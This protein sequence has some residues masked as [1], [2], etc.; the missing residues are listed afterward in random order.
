MGNFSQQIKLR[1]HRQ[2]GAGFTLVELMTV[3]AIIGILTAIGL[4][5]IP[6]QR[7]R[8]RNAQRVVDVNIIQTA[9]ER[10]YAK[11]GTYP[12]VDC[13][14]WDDLH[15]TWTASNVDMTWA[16]LAQKLGPYTG[17]L[18]NDSLVLQT[19]PAGH[20]PY[21][22]L[23]V[24]S[25][26]ADQYQ[27]YVV[28]AGMEKGGWNSIKSLP[29]VIAPWIAVAHL[30]DDSGFEDMTAWNSAAQSFTKCNQTNYLT[31]PIHC[32]EYISAG[33]NQ[34][35]QGNYFPCNGGTTG[36]CEHELRRTL[37]V[38]K[39]QTQGCDSYYPWLPN[40]DYCIP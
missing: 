17:A 5:A 21:Q 7:A 14:Y 35:Y 4:V 22:Y 40:H 28:L 27:H 24:V 1:L 11:N 31:H 18:P 20:Q 10:Y 39:P 23:V 26:A 30:S 3:I 37:C 33:A 19:T 15:T 13:G 38:G 32:G 8:A 12:H 6:D 36:V 9:L 25:G 16:A 2:S 34:V 29:N